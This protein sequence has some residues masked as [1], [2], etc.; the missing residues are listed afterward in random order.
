MY[1]YVD[2]E[3]VRSFQVFNHPNKEKY[4]KVEIIYNNDNAIIYHLTNK[5]CRHVIKAI[6]RQWKNVAANR[7]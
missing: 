4:F 1:E 5:E 3:D 7:E 6:L 2:I